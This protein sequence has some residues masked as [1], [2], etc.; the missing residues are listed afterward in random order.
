MRGYM[1]HV[2]VIAVCYYVFMR[3]ISLPSDTA[4]LRGGDFWTYT[5]V[6]KMV[7]TRFELVFWVSK[8]HVLTEL[9]YRTG[10]HWT[11]YSFIIPFNPDPQCI[12]S[13]T[14][15]QSRPRRNCSYSVCGG[16]YDAGRR[17]TTCDGHVLAF[18]VY[19]RRPAPGGCPVPYIDRMRRGKKD[20]HPERYPLPRGLCTY[21]TR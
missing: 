1:V 18:H 6:Q 3:V 4:L 15:N 16:E 21:R 10:G 5:N 12:K 14:H 2:C 19:S 7:L 9:Y 8:T 13:R 17:A 11:I 20:Q